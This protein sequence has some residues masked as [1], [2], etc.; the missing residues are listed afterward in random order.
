MNGYVIK[1]DIHPSIGIHSSNLCPYILLSKKDAID[2]MQS[3]AK[4]IMSDDDT[5]EPHEPIEQC[6]DFIELV[7][8]DGD[9]IYLNIEKLT[10]LNTN[11]GD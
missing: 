9:I 4:D 5:F 7:N 6:D 10:I 2:T 11:K 8:G 3:H 1:E